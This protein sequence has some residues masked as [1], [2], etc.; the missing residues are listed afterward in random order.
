MRL[1]LRSGS[2]LFDFAGALSLVT[3]AKSVRRWVWADAALAFLGKHS[4]NI[5]LF[6]TFVYSYYFSDFIYSDPNPLIIYAKLLAVCLPLSMAIEWFKRLP[7][8]KPLFYPP[9]RHEPKTQL[10]NG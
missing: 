10:T 3:L 7:P 2:T 9:L 1:K 6:H 5:F 4:M 8:L